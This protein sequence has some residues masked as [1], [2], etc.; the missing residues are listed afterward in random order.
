MGVQLCL[1]VCVYV[2]MCV[3][4]TVCACDILLQTEAKNIQQP[5]TLLY[6]GENLSKTESSTSSP[7]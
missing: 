6:R 2:C 3:Y 5:N 1:C 7:L 4:A